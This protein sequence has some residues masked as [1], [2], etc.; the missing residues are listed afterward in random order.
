MIVR[1]GLA[2]NSNIATGKLRNRIALGC[3]L[4]AGVAF[5]A[6]A[7]FAQTVTLSSNKG[8]LSLSGELRSF[9]GRF[10]QIQ[11][12]FGL[13]TVAGERVYCTGDAC[14]GDA[15][16][17]GFSLS[18]DRGLGQILVPALVRA[19]AAQQ[20][21]PITRGRQSD[22]LQTFYLGRD[23][24]PRRFPIHLRLAGNG[25]AFVDLAL[26]KSDM[27]LTTRGPLPAEHDILVDAGQGDFTSPS[28]EM[29][30][31]V[32]AMILA[33]APGSAPEVV[34]GDTLRAI[35]GGTRDWSQLGAAGTGFT[36]HQ[37]AAS[38]GQ[39]SWLG[40]Q[41][42]AGQVALYPSAVDVSLAVRANRGDL[43]I[44]PYSLRGG[45]QVIEFQGTCGLNVRPTADTIRLGEYPFLRPALAYLPDRRLPRDIVPFIAF[46]RSEMATRVV[47]RAGYVRPNT[48][49]TGE[50][51]LAERVLAGLSTSLADSETYGELAR[52]LHGARKLALG[53]PLSRQSRVMGLLSDMSLE[54]LTKDLSAGAFRGET[55]V[56]AG[57]G[58]AGAAKALADQLQEFATDTTLE[59]HD[60]GAA[61]PLAC[62]DTEWAERVNNRI[63]IWLK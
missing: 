20:G 61:L 8:E 6:T 32:D 38:V 53:F 26:H 44:L 27:A 16:T 47:E 48:K 52:T 1:A 56:I 12:E 24:G 42:G 57:F 15:E 28:Q 17:T 63:E 4:A 36:L 35:A 2:T 14:P 23:D 29:L 31:G 18:V 25:D 41:A 51:H 9:D 58:T 33:A 30:I 45:L 50:T 40:Q 54:T 7:V 3:I 5:C 62:R 46:L 34:T 22:T 43:G 13:V 37:G 19:F 21:L 55:L 11:T 60:F 49:F 10:Y 59:A 39:K